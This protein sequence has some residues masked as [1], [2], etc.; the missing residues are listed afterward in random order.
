M[1]AGLNGVP[2]ETGATTYSA[3]IRSEIAEVTDALIDAATTSA[4][5]MMATPRMSAVAVAAVR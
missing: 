5:P 4:N 2:P 3:S 1:A